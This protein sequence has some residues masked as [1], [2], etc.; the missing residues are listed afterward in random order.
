MRAIEQT[1]RKTVLL[2]RLRIMQHPILKPGHR[3]K[4][5]QFTVT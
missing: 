5:G 4:Q 2:V 3:I 1:V